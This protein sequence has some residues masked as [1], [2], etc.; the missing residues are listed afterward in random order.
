ND[1]PA[2]MLPNGHVFFAAGATPN[3]FGGNVG[4]FDY[5]P[6]ANTITTIGDPWDSSNVNV[7]DT[8]MLVLPTGQVLVSAYTGLYIYTPDGT[9][10]PAWQPTISGITRN[11]NSNFTLT[12]TEL[13]G[14]SEGASYGDDGQMASNYPIVQ[15]TATT[16]TIGPLGVKLYPVS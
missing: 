13:N 3:F 16:P 5:D 14:L 7:F 8:F 2:A 4:F 15:L 6:V 12:G 9:P 10:N 11:G 1:A